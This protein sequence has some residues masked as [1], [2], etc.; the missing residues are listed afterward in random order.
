[1]SARQRLFGNAQ[2]TRGAFA[3]LCLEV[4]GAA[5][6]VFLNDA[7]RA[8]FADYLIA[9]PSTVFEHARVWTLVTTTA[10]QIDFFKLLF[11]AL[12]L[13]MFVPTLERFWGTRR[14]L[15]FAAI[16]S[17][18]GNIC[19]VTTAYLTG[20]LGLA[21]NGLDPFLY[22][23][24]VAFGIVYARQPVRFFGVLPLTGR[25][26]MYGFIGFLVLYISLQQKWEEG[27]WLAT[28]MITA[29]LLTSKKWSPTLAWRKWRIQ[30]ARAKLTVMQGGQSKSAGKRD[31]KQKWLN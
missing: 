29:A 30:R 12:L 7:A 9:T 25:Q 8:R 28:A 24:I 31:E 17:V 27:V 3:L 21:F 2:I 16:T 22:G 18:V 15:S 19:G 4:A 6:F 5:L 10:F 1:M 14:F 13:W 20:Q 26:L 11:N 23:S